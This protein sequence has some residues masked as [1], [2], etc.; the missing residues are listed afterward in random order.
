MV[1][2]S[3]V[4]WDIRPTQELPFVLSVHSV[5]FNKQI[6]RVSF[7]FPVLQFKGKYEMSGKLVGLP[8]TGKGNYELFVSKCKLSICSESSA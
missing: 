6:I 4:F 2:T 1:M 5:D 8:I 7:M 3:S